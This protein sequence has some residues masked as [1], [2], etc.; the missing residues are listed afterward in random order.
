MLSMARSRN[1]DGGQESPLV[2]VDPVEITTTLDGSIA[3]YI[4]GPMENRIV[5]LKTR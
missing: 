3:F 1:R 4:G 5:G 2:V